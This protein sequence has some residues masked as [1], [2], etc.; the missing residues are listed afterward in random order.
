MKKQPLKTTLFLFPTVGNMLWM[1]TFFGV[2]IF[3][4]RMIN[5]DGDL[6]LHLS[7]GRFILNHRKIPLRDV[8]SHTLAGQPAA[9]HK[10]LSQ[11]LF[12]QAERM[13]GLAGVVLLCA[14]VIATTFWLVFE[15]A[16]KESNALVT[17]VLV[18]LLALAASM[19]HWLIRPHV[20]TFLFLALW[21]TILNQL[22]KGKLQ[23]RWL[24]PAL[25]VLWVNLHGGF[26]AGL[27]TWLLYGLGVG[28]DAVW[29]RAPG[30]PTRFWRN[31]LLG[32]VTALLTTLINPSG[33]GLWHMLVTHLGNPYL[34]AITVEFQ[35]PN[36]H[37]VVFWPFL[38][39]IGLLLVVL[40]LS[41]KRFESRLVFS[42]AAWL[43]MGLYSGRNIPL[44]A[45]VAVPLFV[46][47]LD[48][49]FISAANRFQLVERLKQSDVRIQSIDG[50]L[51]GFVWPA[52]SILVVVVGL[53]FGLNLDL[54]GQGYGY[55]PDVFPVAAVDWLEENPQ[56]GEMFN[57][58]TWGGYL[59]YRLWPEKR[60][61]ID[62]NS[63]FYGEAFVRQYI[64]VIMLQEG[65]EDVLDQYDVTWA[66]LPLNESAAGALQS[67]L[68]WGVIYEDETAVILVRE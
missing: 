26:I 66:I 44:F 40:S 36:F 7:M 17:A 49:L 6:A 65:W 38:I 51:Q 9:Q 8:F 63:D 23:H 4:Q 22:Y 14:I 5:A 24:L 32:G 33:M 18:V 61:F 15:L 10:W 21:M 57:Y 31:Y 54:H 59:Q 47:A 20:F 46:Q 45:I 56:E 50:Q 68:D 35:S 34:A 42:S 67:V 62:S 58:F 11:L 60:V 3:G 25:M 13:M 39:M 29:G 16:R 28:W 43:L 30:P 37:Q 41:E 1:A 48:D 64:Q 19:V 12:A 52:L 55:D 53:G 2:L 27:V